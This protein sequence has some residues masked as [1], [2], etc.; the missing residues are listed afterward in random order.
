MAVRR[1]VQRYQVREVL[2]LK[3]LVDCL[4]LKEKHQCQLN[5]ND[6]NCGFWSG[7]ILY[8]AIHHEVNMELNTS[9]QRMF[10]FERYYDLLVHRKKCLFG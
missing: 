9:S 10:I 7:D 5:I 3:Y 1:D 8:D 4:L 2:T 6:I